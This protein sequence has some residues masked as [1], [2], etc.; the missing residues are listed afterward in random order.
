MLGRDKKIIGIVFGGK[1]NE[2]KIS[3]SSAKTVFKAFNSE[4][5]KRRF[6][7]I[8]F[9]INKNGEWFNN[10]QSIKIL[11]DAK[12]KNNLTKSE[13]GEKLNFLEKIGEGLDFTHLLNIS[14]TILFLT[15][16]SLRVKP[17]LISLTPIVA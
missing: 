14:V 8:A 7:V 4:T 1:S 13:N 12:P 9:Y 17:C 11:L 10:E 2:H 5:N 16:L 3:I 6:K 15:I